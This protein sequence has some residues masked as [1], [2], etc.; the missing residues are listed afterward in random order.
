MVLADNIM[1]KGRCFTCKRTYQ[2]EVESLIA[3]YKACNE[4]P[5]LLKE[6]PVLHCS[7]CG[8]DSSP[9]MPVCA[10]GCGNWRPNEE[11]LRRVGDVAIVIGVYGR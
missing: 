1:V 4:D 6:Q 2:D 8:R 10:W 5:R 7:L 11:I 9:Y 3:Y